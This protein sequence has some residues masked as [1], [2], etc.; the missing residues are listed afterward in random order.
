MNAMTVLRNAVTRFMRTRLHGLMPLLLHAI[1]SVFNVFDAD[2]ERAMKELSI[3]TAGGFWL[4]FWGYLL[5]VDRN[6]GAESDALYRERILNVALESKSPN[7]VL[8]DLVRVYSQREPELV[9]GNGTVTVNRDYSD[10]D[11]DTTYT[12]N[13]HLL[14]VHYNTGGN[15]KIAYYMRGFF[16]YSHFP[17]Q[18]EDTLSRFKQL[19]LEQ[20]VARVKIAG[21]KVVFNPFRQPTREVA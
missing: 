4:D 8:I 12:E 7:Q 18:G 10:Y 6:S 13:A 5:G 14:A 20:E 3:H 1:G 17:G 2:F 15:P 21:I 9:E 11:Y 19:Q 16:T